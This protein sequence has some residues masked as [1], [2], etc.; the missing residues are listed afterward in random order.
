MTVDELNDSR[1]ALTAVQREASLHARRLMTTLGFPVGDPGMTD[2]PARLVRAWCELSHGMHLDPGRHLA[3]TFPPESPDPGLIA[4]TDV[5]FVSL[6]EHHLLPFTGTANVAYLPAPGASIVGL[7]KLA[8]LVQEYA[9]RPQVQE[10]LG[11]QIVHALVSRLDC[12][13]A[14]CAITAEHSC[15]TLRGA[16]STGAQMET[17]HLKGA[18]QADPQLRENFLG[19]ART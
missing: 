10:R 13:G 11:E 8:R 6:C 14:A 5:P 19:L 4:V 2:T 3:V 15:M 12:D 18:F 7:S 16:R 1:P 9:A 17:L